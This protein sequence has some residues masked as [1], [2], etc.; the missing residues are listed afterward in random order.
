MPLRANDVS[1]L[2]AS[3][4]RCR[5]EGHSWFDPRRKTTKHE[6]VGNHIERRSTCASCGTR[7]AQLFTPG[8]KVVTYP[9]Y[10]YPDGY[11][12]VKG[13][14]QVTRTEVRKITLRAVA[15]IVRRSA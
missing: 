14:T 1:E 13:S 9:K 6:R 10:D 8:G 11:L 7:K 2:S 15:A 4:L 3:F 5:D 12:L